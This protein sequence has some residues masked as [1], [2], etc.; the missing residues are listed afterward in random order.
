MTKLKQSLG[1][2]SLCLYGLGAILGAGI[3]SVIGEAAGIAHE[4]LWMSFLA[5]GVVALLTALSY[6]ELATLFPKAGGELVYL[7]RALPDQ[8]WV[9][10][11]VGSMVALSSGSWCGPARARTDSQRRSRPHP[12]SRCWQAHRS[13]SFRS[14]A[15]RTS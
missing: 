4:G 6:A 10:F 2:V 1:T 13:C 8:D 7:R 12:R 11:T 15:S 9:A 14:S 5:A 3:Y